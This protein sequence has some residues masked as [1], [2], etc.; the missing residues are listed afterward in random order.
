MFNIYGRY[1]NAV[2]NQNNSTS[3]CDFQKGVKETKPFKQSL[4]L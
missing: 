4:K 3:D 1:N 2:S